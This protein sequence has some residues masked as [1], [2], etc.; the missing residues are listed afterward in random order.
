MYIWI[1]LA[2]IMIALSFFNLS[3]RADKE[4]V[5]TEVKALSLISRFKIEHTAFS[6]VV[7]C[8][9][10]NSTTSDGATG[11]FNPENGVDKY[12]WENEALPIGYERGTDLS[13]IVHYHYCLVDDVELGGS[14][15][16]ATNCLNSSETPVHRYAVT[17]AKIP[18]RWLSKDNGD[19][20]P[21]LNNALSKQYVKGSILG[22]STCAVN[23]ENTGIESCTFQGTASYIKNLKDSEDQQTEAE[24][25]KGFLSFDGSS[26]FYRALFANSDFKNDCGGSCFFAIHKLSNKDVD[27]HCETLYKDYQKAINTSPFVQGDDHAHIDKP[28]I[29]EP[30][31]G[32]IDKPTFVQEPGGQ[33]PINEFIV[34]EP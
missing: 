29:G 12:I 6:R 11:K 24:P 10:L 1:L 22:I 28:T 23:G 17:F 20:I 14:P 7:E 3:P 31:G 25:R 2:T 27:K 4:G 15:A 16:L 34:H 18:D 19:I 32:S 30:I 8:K 5:F 21:V 26:G 9:L 13:T 33:A